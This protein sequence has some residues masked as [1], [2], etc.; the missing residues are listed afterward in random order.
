VSNS[1]G[2][3]IDVKVNRDAQLTTFLPRPIT[4]FVFVCAGLALPFALV[5]V[6]IP[7][8]SACIGFSWFSVGF[9]KAGTDSKFEPASG[10]RGLRADDEMDGEG[11]MCL[12]TLP[13]GTGG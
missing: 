13:F 4:G 3:G 11:V 12:P 10:F 2:T 7:A 8:R 9:E 5:G 1:N 6:R